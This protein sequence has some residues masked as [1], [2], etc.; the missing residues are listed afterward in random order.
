[1][2][3]QLQWVGLACFLLRQE[4]GSA[5]AMDPYD[6]AVVA[7]ACGIADPALLDFRLE[8]DTVI[9]S[10]L[11]DQAHAYHQA[12]AGEPRVIN[13]LD[14]AQGREERVNA[15][16]LYAVQAAEAPHHPQG[17][18]DNALYAF[19]AGGLWF[20]HMG[21][22]G[23]GIGADEL[24]PFAGP[25]RRA[26][27]PGGREPHLAAGRAGPHDRHPRPDL[28][29]AHA[30]Q[31]G[32]HHRGDDHARRV[33][34][35]PLPASAHLPA[36][37]HGDISPAR[38]WTR[39]TDHR[40]AGAVRLPADAR[41][42]AS[43]DLAALGAQLSKQGF[44]VLEGLLEPDLLAEL[45]SVLADLFARERETPYDPGDGP[46][47]P[48]DAEI[49][50]YLAASYAVS[51]SELDRML[52]RIR[53]TRAQNFDT[54]WPVELRKLNKTFIHIPNLFDDDRSQYVR[55]LP[56][57]T[58]LAD[59]LAAHPVV[60]GLA[61]LLLGGD[62]VIG[63]LS[64]TS[65][66][67]G[68]RGGSWH[69][70]NPLTQMREPLPDFPLGIQVAWMID[71]FTHQ[72]GATRIV[73]GSHLTRR[74]PTWAKGER[75]DEVALTAPAGSAA[76][77]LGQHLAPRWA[78]LHQWPAARC[79]LL[80]SMLLDQAVLGVPGLHHRGAGGPNVAGGALSLRAV[81]VRRRT[82][83]AARGETPA[84]FERRS[85]PAG[86]VAPRSH[87]P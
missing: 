80:L 1:M 60:H 10:S 67:A 86:C 62:C 44:V 72:N 20:L 78:Q 79:H 5:I 17:P 39:P 64:A 25:L 33:P 19:R 34:G 18:D 71:D 31:P 83:L 14:V 26:A 35:A 42:M 68:T 81:G 22:L 6:P 50:A 30:L 70:D 28:D 77:W 3:V 76:I 11:T 55:N 53:H 52:R 7:A 24:A 49:R 54:A 56:V 13:A 45:R 63:D 74:K 43:R 69:L 12:V 75:D 59:R 85:I 23:Y 65:I 15:E 2:A 38:G 47:R 9:V 8:A 61:A 87:M 37:P 58:E 16:P 21:D 29:R 4:D 32:A 51:D 36:A 40:S 57:K 82:G 46:A 66:G 41:L 84:A 73:P 48:Q 27:G